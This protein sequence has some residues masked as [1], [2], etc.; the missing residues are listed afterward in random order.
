MK[1]RSVILFFLIFIFACSNKETIIEYYSDNSIHKKY[2]LKNNVIE[3]DYLEY[4]DN[5]KIKSKHIYKNGVKVDSSLFYNQNPYFLNQIDFYKKKDTVY[6]V[7]LYENG[8]YSD[9]GEFLNQQQIGKWT[10]YKKTGEI[11]KIIEYIN[12]KGTQ[13][14]NQGWYF[15]KDGDTIKE[16]GNYYRYK[17][18]PKKIQVGEAFELEIEYKPLL[19]VNGDVIALIHPEVNPDFSNI[20]SISLDTIIFYDNKAYSQ[21]SF[22]DKGEKNLRGCIQETYNKNDSVSRRL[23]YIN[24][25]ISVH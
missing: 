20:D 11:D 7:F 24:I 3:G 6:S 25:P 19:V 23:L 16:F 18:N 9:E 8:Q 17:L 15:N 13:Y 5:G 1:K 14:T 21:I 12:L 10:F 2:T 22:K 4:F